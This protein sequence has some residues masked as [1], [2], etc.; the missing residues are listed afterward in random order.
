MQL[1]SFIVLLRYLSFLLHARVTGNFLYTWDKP[2]TAFFLYFV[3]YAISTIL[4]QVC[5]PT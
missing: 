3:L 1:P 2:F 5:A 4:F